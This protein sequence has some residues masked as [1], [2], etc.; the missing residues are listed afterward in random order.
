MDIPAYGGRNLAKNLKENDK[1]FLW[2][3]AESVREK[4]FLKKF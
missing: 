1:K 3:L 2:S 4:K